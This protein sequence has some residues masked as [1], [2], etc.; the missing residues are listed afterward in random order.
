MQGF[1]RLADFPKYRR[2]AVQMSKY[3]P[4]FARL[5]EISGRLKKF[6]PLQMPF[7]EPPVQLT[8][9]LRGKI[10]FVFKCVIL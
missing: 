1:S 7:A 2:H 9:F 3:P 8:L 10:L 5:G 6:V 4:V